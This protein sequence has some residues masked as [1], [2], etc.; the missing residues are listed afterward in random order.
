[1]TNEQR[2]RITDLRM[3]GLG[4]TAI[5][6]KVGLS[7]DSVKAYCRTHKLGGKLGEPVSP[8]ATTP[9]EEQATESEDSAEKFTGRCR[10]CGALFSRGGKTKTRKYCSA[11]CRQ[12]WW[13]SH[14]DQVRQKALYP[15]VCPECGK[16]FTAYGN[17]HRKYCSRACYFA[18]RFKRG[19][20]V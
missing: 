3:Q 12:K 8:R 7:R 14:P 17:D 10:N 15:Y 1:M 4:Y 20:H 18:G 13:N 16:S 9:T 11:E 5:A 2:N 19:M 6:S